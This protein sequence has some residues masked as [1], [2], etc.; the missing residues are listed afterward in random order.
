MKVVKLWFYDEK[1][2]ILLEDGR[3]L[4]QSL[5]WYPRLKNATAQQR[6]N[7]TIKNDG[8]RWVEPDE[9]IS[10]ESFLYDDPE[11]SG[12]AFIFRRFPELNASAIAR[13]L[14]MKQS[15]L[16]AYI[17]GVKKPSVEQEKRIEKA[18]RDFAK[19]LNAIG[20]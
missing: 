13:R 18:I 12:V 16:A 4:W 11:P 10:L 3:E 8:I 6:E 19:E 7:Y 1:I 9:D 20:R 2:C 5:L 14:G 15:L 17:S